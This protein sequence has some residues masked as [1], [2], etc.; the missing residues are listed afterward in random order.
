[1]VWYLKNKKKQLFYLLLWHN[2][3]FNEKTIIHG[4]IIT[5]HN[6]DYFQQQSLAFK[7]TST[8]HKIF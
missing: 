1:M 8:K 3:L 4:Q 5:S 6:T 2:Y 7:E